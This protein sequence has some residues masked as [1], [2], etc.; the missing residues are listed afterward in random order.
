MCC[1]YGWRDT[2]I[3][4]SVR[5]REK[6]WWWLR[7][8]G[9]R[10][11][12]RWKLKRLFNCEL[13]VSRLKAPAVKFFAFLPLFFPFFFSLLFFSIGRGRDAG[14]FSLSQTIFLWLP[15]FRFPYA[16]NLHLPLWTSFL[17]YRSEKEMAVSGVA[18]GV[19]EEEKIYK[20][21]V[22]AIVL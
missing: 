17:H 7:S 6:P 12:E 1:F 20:F 13:L 4:T 21:R 22:D 16:G 8:S 11:N 2:S 5:H 3:Y 10:G 18:A 19:S 15:L 9:R 14:N